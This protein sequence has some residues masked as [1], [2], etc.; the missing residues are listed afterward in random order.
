MYE[1][2]GRL[3]FSVAY[4][5]LGDVQLA[6]DA[7]Q[8]TFVQAWRAAST[9]DSDRPPPVELAPPGCP[10]RVPAVLSSPRAPVGQPPVRPWRSQR[11]CGA[12]PA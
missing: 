5:V 11:R 10:R 2:Y 12:R 3:V 7:A 8:Q 6:E 4:K 9:Y 1:R